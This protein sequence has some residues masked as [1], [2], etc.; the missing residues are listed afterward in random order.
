MSSGG[1]DGAPLTGGAP[2]EAFDL[3]VLAASA[4]GLNALSAV[5]GPL[6]ADLPAAVLV[7]QHLDPRHRSLLDDILRRRTKLTVRLAAEG[8]PIVPGTVLIAPPDHHLLV[9]PDRTV[10]LSQSALVHFVRPSADLL[11][12]SAAGSYREKVIAVI[13]TGSG[14]DG[15]MGVSAVKENGGTVIAQDEA[16]SQFFSMPGAAIQTGGVDFVLPLDEIG[17]ALVELVTGGRAL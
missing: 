12:E 17:P 8:D 14:S 3:V 4:G 10:S 2:A 13:L 6:P 5:L 16:T 9:N 1:P 11:F 15:S 7:V